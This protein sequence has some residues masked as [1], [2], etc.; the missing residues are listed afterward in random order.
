MKPIVLVLLLLPL[1]AAANVTPTNAFR[2]VAMPARGGDTGFPI[3][4]GS[5]TNDAARKAATIAAVRADAPRNWYL[6]RLAA[7]NTPVAEPADPARADVLVLPLGEYAVDRGNPALTEILMVDEGVCRGVVSRYRR[8]VVAP[9][10]L[11]IRISHAGAPVGRVEDLFFVPGDGV[12]A[13]IAVEASV[14][15]TNAW[16]VSPEL[17][18][19]RQTAADE[20]G[21]WGELIVPR[22]VTGLAL[23]TEPSIPGLQRQ[24]VQFGVPDAGPYPAN[25]IPIHPQQ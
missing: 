1:V 4:T 14:A 15:A 7:T 21:A 18:C 23:T 10:N 16:R 20:W 22:H 25:Y 2:H 3:A 8:G 19:F 24:D 17:Y 6:S 13:R 5:V 12:W 11:P 9:T